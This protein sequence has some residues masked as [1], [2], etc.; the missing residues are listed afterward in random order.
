MLAVYASKIDPKDP[1]SGLEVGDRPDPE[2][3]D[4]ERTAY[5]GLIDGRAARAF[6]R[7]ASRLW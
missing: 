3:P 2:V 1:L 7:R 5:R 6:C 4:G